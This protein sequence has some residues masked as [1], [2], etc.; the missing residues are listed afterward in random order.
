MLNTEQ[1]LVTVDAGI[2]KKKLDG[3]YCVQKRSK[4]FAMQL[5]FKLKS[6]K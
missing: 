2:K 1:A 4:D 5:G 6:T 3:I